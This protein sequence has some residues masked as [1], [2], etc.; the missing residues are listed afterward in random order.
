MDYRIFPPDEILETTVELPPSKSAAARAMVMD[1]V[2]G[3]CKPLTENLACHD[4]DCRDIAVLASILAQGVPADGRDVDADASGTALRMLTAL[5]AAIPGAHCRITG[6]DSLR[7]RPIGP[8][9]DALRQ[10]GADIAWC[11]RE[12]FAPVEIKGS[13]LAGGTITLDPSVSS[14]FATALMLAAPLMEKPLTIIYKV[15]TVSGPYVKLTAQMMSAR[16]VAAGHAHAF[17]VGLGGSY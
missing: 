9:V 15:P 2:A 7:S 10:L 13:R 11:V 16:G 3:G 14:Q 8:L 6:T 4:G 17:R 1:F 5:Y 12:G